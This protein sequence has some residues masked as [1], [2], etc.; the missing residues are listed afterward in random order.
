MK[1]HATTSVILY[2]T[3]KSF[4]KGS[5]F[6]KLLG[7]ILLSTILFSAISLGTMRYVNQIMLDRETQAQ[8]SYMDYNIKLINGNMAKIYNMIRSMTIDTDMTGKLDGYTRLGMNYYEITGIKQIF[9]KLS[10]ARLDGDNLVGM[11][12]YV[13]KDDYVVTDTGVMDASLFFNLRFEEKADAWPAL[14]QGRQSMRIE[15]MEIHYG[16]TTTHGICIVNTLYSKMR[17]IGALVVAINPEGLND[18]SVFADFT[19]DRP[20]CLM[21]ESGKVI[22]NLSG[23]DPSVFSEVPEL[24]GPK[25]VS[26]QLDGYLVQTEKT[27]VAGLYLAVM[28]PTELITGS[29]SP[30]FDLT[31]VIIGAT[32]LVGVILSLVLSQRIYKPVL[33]LLEL[34]RGI[35]SPSG[36]VLRSEFDIIERNV[37]G[38]LK[39]YE[40]MERAVVD[41]TPL[42]LE[43]I[44]KKIIAGEREYDA[45]GALLQELSIE[46]KEGLYL[47]VAVRVQCPQRTQQEMEYFLSAGLRK[48]IRRHLDDNVISMFRMSEDT[49][50]VVLYLQDESALPRVAQRCDCMHAGVLDEMGAITCAIGVGNPYSDPYDIGKSYRNA[51]QTLE[52]S[53]VGSAQAVL[54]YDPE[55]GDPAAHDEPVIPND[56]ENRLFQYIMSGNGPMAVELAQ[57]TLNRNYSLGISVAAYNKLLAALQGYAR[58]IYDAMDD[59]GR[60][61]VAFTDLQLTDNRDIDWASRVVLGNY[62]AIAGYYG[63]AGSADLIGRIVGYIDENLHRDIY[64][65][66]IAGAMGLTPNY[67]T[68]YFRKQKGI[69]FKY[70]VNAKRI[71]KAKRLLSETGTMVKSIAE[72]CG[73]NSSK[74][75]I[76]TFTKFVGATPIEYRRRCMPSNANSSDS[77][78]NTGVNGC[79]V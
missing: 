54:V 67:I 14:M 36:R 53:R 4:K 47:A 41:S 37:A 16:A 6:Y 72:L 32:F 43:A 60:E 74:R 23:H 38:I 52:N 1:N 78:S 55:A 22:A 3:A 10:T 29:I 65:D 64:L 57:S 9:N 11:F 15:P 42:L 8:I 75:F 49:L 66:E 50:A 76:A 71:E 73:F 59:S 79:A 30:V 56:L 24:L 28:T 69:N 31:A 20:V 62:N 2:R 46:F 5:F 68:R 61:A 70:Y 45:I 40:H 39:N 34:L 35:K 51:A 25:H 77:S 48:L 27:S 12:I 21:D 19:R 44:F 63:I 26:Q 58:R 18:S 7:V 13:D 17:K 33:R